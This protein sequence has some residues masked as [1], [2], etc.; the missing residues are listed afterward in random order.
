MVNINSR[1]DRERPNNRLKADL[2]E[3][4]HP[5]A[6]QSGA[7]GAYNTWLVEGGIVEE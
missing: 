2:G 4:A 1:R 3:A 6:A 7:L 5:S